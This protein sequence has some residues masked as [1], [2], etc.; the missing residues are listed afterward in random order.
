MG[1]PLRSASLVASPLAL[2]AFRPKDGLQENPS[3]AIKWMHGC[4][5]PDKKPLDRAK[6]HMQ[7]CFRFSAVACARILL[8]DRLVGDSVNCTQLFRF[9]LRD[10]GAFCLKMAF[11]GILSQCCTRE[12]G[13]TKGEIDR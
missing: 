12:K 13:G 2:L 3:A 8:R 10:K 4:E 11:R 1:R 6:K 7:N 5:R 9:L